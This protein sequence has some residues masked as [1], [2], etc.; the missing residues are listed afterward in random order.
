[1]PS[2]QAADDCSHGNAHFF[3]LHVPQSN[4]GEDDQD[5]RVDIELLRRDLSKV[6]TTDWK[7]RPGDRC[8]NA[9]ADHQVL[10]SPEPLVPSLA[11]GSVYA[12]STS[13]CDLLVGMSNVVVLS[14]SKGM[15]DC[16]LR[17]CQQS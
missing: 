10:I 17:D 7:V 6:N 4:R 8:G 2:V 15:S 3:R 1:M 12:W 16:M 5:W 9:P 11:Q 13:V 14:E